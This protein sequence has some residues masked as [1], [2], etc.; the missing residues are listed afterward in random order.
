M[1]CTTLMSRFG[2]PC[3]CADLEYATGLEGV[4]G[5]SSFRVE[6]QQSPTV[7]SAMGPL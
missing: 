3:C 7:P 6:V 2:C 1:G 5:F 4:A